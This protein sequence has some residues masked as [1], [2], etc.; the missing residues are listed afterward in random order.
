MVTKKYLNEL[1]YQII[2]AAIEV[3]KNLGPGLLE[4]V[5]HKCLEREFYLRNISFSS[6]LIVP[7]HYKG[8][9][10]NAELR[11][12]FLV[13]NNIV[14]ELKTI[15]ELAPVHE[16]PVINLHEATQKTKR[17]IDQLLLLQLI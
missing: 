4:S 5:Y 2:G 11:C 8:V 7:V 12:D 13:D 17:D 1:T 3:H 15:A 14:T 9:E 16:A 6:E 10:V